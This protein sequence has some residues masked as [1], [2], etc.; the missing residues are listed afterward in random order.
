MSGC[1]S[2]GNT[3][4][5]AAG[6]CSSCGG[7]CGQPKVVVTQQGLPGVSGG[8]LLFNNNDV[9][10][11]AAGVNGNVPN[12]SYQFTD[13]TL[14][15]DGDALRV[16]ALFSVPENNRQSAIV[17]SGS[18]IGVQQTLYPDGSSGMSVTTGL[19][20]FMDLLIT[21][22]SNTEVQSIGTITQIPNAVGSTNPTFMTYGGVPFTE[23]RRNPITGMD[24]DNVPYTIQLLVIA[25][26][27]DPEVADAYV[28]NLTVEKLNILVS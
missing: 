28:H 6:A 25:V 24:L 17:I 23:G 4:Y 5:S 18:G 20:S 11:L 14:I 1:S 3:V 22:K 19:A 9:E 2:C 15:N 12:M 21:R 7:D 16:Q 26:P 13:G 10:T 27:G 8:D